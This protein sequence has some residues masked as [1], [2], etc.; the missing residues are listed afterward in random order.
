V[1][2]TFTKP[3]RESVPPDGGPQLGDTVAARFK[4][5][6][7]SGAGS[8]AVV[9]RAE[10]LVQGGCVALKVQYATRASRKDRAFHEARALAAVQHSAVVGYIAHGHTEQ[11]AP[12][13]AMQW[14]GGETLS[15]RLA[16]QGLTPLESLRLAVRLSSG[17]AALHA[18]RIVHRDLKPS[19]ILLPDGRV[20][21]ACIVDLGVS[22]DLRTPSGE[23]GH[24]EYIGTP[25]YM[26]PEQIRDPQSVQGPS[27][28]FAL[29]CILHECLCG[30]PAFDEAEVFAVLAQI[31]FAQPAPVSRVRPELPSGLDEL[32]AALLAR[33]PELRPAAGAVLNSKLRAAM[34]LSALTELGRPDPAAR[35][36]RHELTADSG[37]WSE[38]LAVS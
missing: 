13:L 27:D 37:P 14:I 33:R 35:D 36:A 8:S 10:D 16:R 32:V 3:G 11:G 6:A 5:V 38:A 4:V 34:A 30:A 17:L 12:Y 20:D 2:R 31:L 1:N 19:N 9:F 21:R 24:G 28:V 23:T 25:R 7:R 18:R 29:G 15:A 22:R 26:S